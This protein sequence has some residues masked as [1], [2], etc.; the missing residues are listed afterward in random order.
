MKRKAPTEG[1]CRQSLTQ[2]RRH[3]SPA[4]NALAKTGIE[5]GENGS[6]RDRWQLSLPQGVLNELHAEEREHGE[7]REEH[8][9]EHSFPWAKRVRLEGAL[10][11]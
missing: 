10:G 8:Q 7:D 2:N 4:V 5:L 9:Y 6:I 3:H 1:R 11:L